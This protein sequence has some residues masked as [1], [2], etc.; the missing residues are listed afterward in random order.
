M[1]PITYIFLRCA[2]KIVCRLQFLPD[3]IFL[4]LRY[5]CEMGQWPN[6]K[7]P[8][9]FQEKIQW[10]KLHNRK[11][12]YTMMVDKY[13]V[14]SYV[15]DIIGDDMITPT[16]GVWNTV[17]EINFDSLPEQFVLKT[18][19]GGGNGGV[20]ICTDKASFDIQTAKIKLKRSMRDDIYSIYREWPYKDVPKRII[21][22]EYIGDGKNDLTDYKVYCFN[23]EPRYIQVIKDRNTCETIDFFDTEWNHQPFWGLNPISRPSGLSIS[24][25]SGLSLM[26]SA[27]KSIAE[28]LTFARIDFYQLEDGIRF[29][30][31]TF[32][33]A[34]GLGTFTP[35]EWNLKLGGMINLPPPY[36]PVNLLIKYS[37]CCAGNLF[38]INKAA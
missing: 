6:L 32:F 17:D 16:I 12:E 3:E 35:A 9:L 5:F 21:A 38:T 8:K 7:N 1:N 20:V 19:H 18:T 26:L 28:K 10:L 2:N 33:P 31:I 34:S 37:D 11:P 30:E 14:K 22:E 24:R 15:A 23:G 27:S 36:N 29:G 25:P 4:K 13:A